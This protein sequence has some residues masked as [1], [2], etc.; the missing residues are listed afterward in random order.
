MQVVR[1]NELCFCCYKYILIFTHSSVRYIN[2]DRLYFL[3]KCGI[4]TTIHISC[5]YKCIPE[6]LVCT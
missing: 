2:C 4:Y 5:D 3:F 1:Y 6:K